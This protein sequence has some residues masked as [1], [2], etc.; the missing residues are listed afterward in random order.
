MRAIQYGVVTTMTGWACTAISHSDPVA[1]LFAAFV[2]AIGGLF[3]AA[4]A[5]P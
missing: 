2:A 1:W 5:G 4:S 3:A